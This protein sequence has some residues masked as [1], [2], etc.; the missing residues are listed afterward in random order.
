[1]IKRRGIK[2]IMVCTSTIKSQN[3]MYHSH[4]SLQ[5]ISNNFPR[6]SNENKVENSG[7]NSS[8]FLVYI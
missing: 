3:T 5:K 4:Y 8:S 7:R 2:K 1:M 6:S